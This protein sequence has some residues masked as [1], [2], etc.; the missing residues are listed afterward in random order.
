[1][2]HLTLKQVVAGLKY[3]HR[4]LKVVCGQLDCGNVLVGAGKVKIGK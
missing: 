4:E 3:V 1:M 2:A